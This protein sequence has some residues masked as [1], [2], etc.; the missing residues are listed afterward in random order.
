MNNK[1]VL[2]NKMVVFPPL[3]VLR[4][5]Q[6]IVTQNAGQVAMGR[7][8]LPGATWLARLDMEVFLPSYGVNLQ[9][10]EVWTLQQKG[11]LIESILM[12]RSIPPLVLNIHIKKDDGIDVLDGKQ[13]LTAIIQF[14]RGDVKFPIFGDEW[15]FNELPEEY[16]KAI[17]RWEICARRGE[18][19]T[20]EEMIQV[21]TSIN[22]LG[23]P[24]DEQHKNR[25]L[26][27][28]Q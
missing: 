15:T 20:E 18:D 16:K 23:T 12:N 4:K 28:I 1:P 9:R 10:E 19:L 2:K 11:G 17:L 24:Q 27:M 7:D 14:L 8:L 3:E 13:R 22:F 6:N 21:F 26:N 5:G 25:L